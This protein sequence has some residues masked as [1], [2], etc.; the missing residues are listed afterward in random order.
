M[1][2]RDAIH[3]YEKYIDFKLTEWLQNFNEL[4]V[5]FSHL[6]LKLYYPV[7]GLY[8][9]IF[10]SYSTLTYFLIVIYYYLKLN[11]KFYQVFIS[12]QV[13]TRITKLFTLWRI[14]NGIKVNPDTPAISPNDLI[15]PNNAPN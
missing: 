10:F 9:C 11:L 14:K 6:F 1:S 8:S 4:M 13:Q 2:P 7:I 3:I 5:R 12:N 15:A